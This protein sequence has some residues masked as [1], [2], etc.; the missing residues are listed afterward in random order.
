MAP[1]YSWYQRDSKPTPAVEMEP[2][3]QGKITPREFLVWDSHSVHDLRWT[4]SK[5]DRNACLSKTKP[6]QNSP[7]FF[8]VLSCPVRVLM[9]F[10][11]YLHRHPP[12]PQEENLHND[13]LSIF[14]K[15]LL[16]AQVSLP[17]IYIFALIIKTAIAVAEI[18]VFLMSLKLSDDFLLS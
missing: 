12:L 6:K 2:K 17:S 10:R 8:S 9:S 15:A 18:N 13:F 5:K 14:L 4:K 7:S 1:V 16:T 3:S 11:Y